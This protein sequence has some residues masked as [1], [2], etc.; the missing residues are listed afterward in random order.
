MSNS[1]RS[2]ALFTV[3]VSLAVAACSAQSAGEAT[4]KARCQGCHGATGLADTTVG[5]TLKVKPVTDQAVRKFTEPAMI[6][7]TRNGMGKMQAFK[8][9]LTDPELK[10]AVAYF[11]ALVK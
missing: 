11:H 4:Y 8:D 7:I 1:I 6:D 5:R 2:I 3:V 10:G 9:K